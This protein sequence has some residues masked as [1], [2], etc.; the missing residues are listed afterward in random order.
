[1]RPNRPSATSRT[2]SHRPAG[3]P[4]RGRPPSGCRPAGRGPGRRP[5]S[6]LRPPSPAASASTNPTPPRRMGSALRAT[7]LRMTGLPAQRHGPLGRHDQAEMLPLP[8]PLPDLG[9]DGLDPVRDLGDQDDVAAA[10]HAGVER[11]PAR[12]PAHDLDDHDPVV[13][14]GRRVQAVDGLGGDADRGVEAERDVRAA[15]VVVDRLGDADDGQAV[16]LQ[17]GRRG[18]GAVPADQDQRVQPG[19]AG[20]AQQPARDVAQHDPARAAPRRSDRDRPCWTCPGW[21]RPGSGC[22]R[23]RPA[24]KRPAAAADEPFIAVLDADDVPAVLH[25]GRLGHRPDDRVDAGAVAAAGQ[26]ADGRLALA[27]EP[28]IGNPGRA[29]NKPARCPALPRPGPVLL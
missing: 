13:G 24:R 26:D 21:C 2:A 20:V 15:E 16:A 3:W 10:G 25:H 29:V 7:S 14:L 18:Q 4:G 17:L 12:P 22:P 19:L 27:H 11:D 23:R 6:P 28:T 9:R 8:A 5:G 1:M